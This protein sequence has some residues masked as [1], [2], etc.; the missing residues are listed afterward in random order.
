MKSRRRP[1]QTSVLSASGDLTT[2]TEPLS[3]EVDK[4]FHG[5][6]SAPLERQGALRSETATG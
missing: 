2:T 4:F 1:G 6:R 5:L 3:R